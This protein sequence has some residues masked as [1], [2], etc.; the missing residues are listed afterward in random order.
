MRDIHIK[1]FV[2][3][4]VNDRDRWHCKHIYTLSFHH[5]FRSDTEYWQCTHEYCYWRNGG[6]MEVDVRDVEQ[7]RKVERSSH[8]QWNQRNNEKLRALP[9]SLLKYRQTTG[10]NMSE[11]DRYSEGVGER[12]RENKRG[13][14]MR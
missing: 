9:C 6:V 11:R 3:V 13:K 5:F 10:E 1:F 7:R 4:V 8:S 2:I 14:E 12:E